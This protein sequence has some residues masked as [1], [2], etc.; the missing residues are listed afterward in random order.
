MLKEHFTAK[1]KKL[2][3]SKKDFAKLTG[4]PYNTVN[5]WSDLKR[6]I[7]LWVESWLKN[8]TQMKELQEKSELTPSEELLQDIGR[9]GTLF[10]DKKVNLILKFIEDMK[11]LDNED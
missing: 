11:A 5:N 10:N 2:G 4:I 6:P 7:P 1:L 3:L 8:Y 9:F